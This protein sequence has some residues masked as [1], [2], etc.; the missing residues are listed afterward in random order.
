MLRGYTSHRSRFFGDLVRPYFT[1]QF[2]PVPH[3]PFIRNSTFSLERFLR[4][5]PLLG[6]T[7]QALSLERERT[8]SERCIP[9]EN[10]YTVRSRGVRAGG[11]GVL[12][13]ILWDGDGCGRSG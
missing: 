4:S 3:T 9:D 12:Y 10:I 5:A 1:V 8:A 11:A 7:H 6:G 2:Y 13:L